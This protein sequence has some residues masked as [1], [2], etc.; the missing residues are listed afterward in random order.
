MKV[1][2]L[3]MPRSEKEENIEK[4]KSMKVNNHTAK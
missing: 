4:I 1:S 2:S 3:A